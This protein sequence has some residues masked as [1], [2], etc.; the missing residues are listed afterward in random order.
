MWE[1]WTG[2]GWRAP[3]EPASLS[4]DNL[5]HRQES[6]RSLINKHNQF[7]IKF[8][9][10]DIPDPT[11]IYIFRGKKYICEKIEMSVGQYGVHREK[12][13]YFYEFL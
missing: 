6:M 8:I 7:T 12:T 1:F 5:T 4:L 2:D 11:R 9:T 10:D 13:G 3:K